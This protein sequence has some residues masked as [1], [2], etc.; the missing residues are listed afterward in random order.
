[1]VYY[2][3]CV[4]G[5]VALCYVLL[6]SQPTRKQKLERSGDSRKR[7]LRDEEHPESRWYK[8]YGLAVAADRLQGPYLFSLYKDEYNLDA[9]RVVSLYMTDAVTT[10]ISAYFIGIL[11]DKYG[12]KLC[13]MIYC[14][15]YALSCFLTIVPVMPLLFLGRILGGISTS[16]LYTAFDSWMVTGFHKGKLDE[17]GCDLTRTYAAT[18]VVSSL[19]AIVSSVLGEGLVWATGTKKSPFLVSVIL[20]WFALQAIWSSWAENFG[21]RALPNRSD[22]AA[23]LSVW[24]V[25]KTPSILALMFAS[26]LF[27]GSMNL[28]LFYWMPALSSLHKSPGELPYGVIHSSFMA[29][30]MA[31]ALAFNIIMDK[32][33]VRY[34]RLLVSVLSVAVFGF[35][36]LAG[37]KTEAGAF[38]LFCLLEACR[39]MFGPSV[40]YLKAKL[41]ND[42]ARATV[43][44]A[45]RTP[46]NILVIISLLVAKDNTN[47]NGVF[48]TCSLMLTAA[49]T[50]MWVASLRGMP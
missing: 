31:A 22:S 14:V 38:W 32:R 34:S 45:I 1:M 13:C 21:A 35:V 39:G 9:G 8:A 42:D 27:D 20:L 49:F 6:I 16:I 37:A 43:Y 30:S 10:A 2:Q 48:T 36:K 46:F 7:A 25:L 29:A 24:S 33:I 4:G 17:E 47:I 5:L 26:T 3:A 50:T 18:G 40:G 12:R 44:S 11:S 41:V 28:F 19:V 15:L 23:G